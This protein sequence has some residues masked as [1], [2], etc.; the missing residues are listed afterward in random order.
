MC[1]YIYIYIIQGQLENNPS[2]ILTKVDFTLFL[3]AWL[4][5]TQEV[6]WELGNLKSLTIIHRN[7]NPWSLNYGW[8]VNL[9]LEFLNPWSPKKNIRAWNNF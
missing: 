1:I 6:W 2:Q 4:V 8:T 3:L 9:V 5:K 7:K